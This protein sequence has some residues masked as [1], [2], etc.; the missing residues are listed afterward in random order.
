MSGDCE[1]MRRKGCESG[2]LVVK[3]GGAENGGEA[4]VKKG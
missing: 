2:G 4:V 3:D 1:G